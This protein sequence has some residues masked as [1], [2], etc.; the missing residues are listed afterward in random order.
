MHLFN[1]IWVLHI[2]VFWYHTAFNPLTIYAPNSSTRPTLAMQRSTMALGGMVSSVIMILGY[3]RRV[4]YIPTT[5]NNASHLTRR[6][7]FLCITLSLTAGPM[8][9]LLS[10]TTQSREVGC[11]SRSRLFRLPSHALRRS[12]LASY[13]LYE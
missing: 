6:P 8:F 12:Y 13:P 5:W 11:R 9:M 2:S 1:R 7:L 10:L 3:T 4:L